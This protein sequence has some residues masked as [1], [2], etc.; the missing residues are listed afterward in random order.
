MSCDEVQ[1]LLGAYAL[2][3]VDSD[4]AAAVEAH[5]VGCP[6][7]RAELAGFREVTGLFAYAGQD[8]P[9]GLWDRIAASMQEDPPPL[10]L[11]R[12]RAA[13][14][15]R[16]TRARRALVAI[17]VAAA[18][19]IVALAVAVVHLD[20]RRPAQ[21]AGQA[22]VA[23]M[24]EVRAALSSPGRRA[25]VLQA[26][27]GHGAHLDVVVESDGTG[28]LYGST[29]RPLANDRTYQLWGVV[30]ASGRRISYGLLGTDPR[31]EEFRAGVGLRALAVTDEVASGVVA[32]TQPLTVEGAVS[33]PL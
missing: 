12:I 8:A 23:T 3:A 9:A 18:V 31:I 15:G 13:G 29:L 26:P 27:G 21:T 4:E 10:R 25:V 7:C 33:P 11:E 16:G 30:G 5:L 2:D 17:A 6:R 20:D 24:A 19:A 32:T 28:F 1:E 14:S 22:P